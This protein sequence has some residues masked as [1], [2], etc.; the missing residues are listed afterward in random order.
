MVVLQWQSCEFRK[1]LNSLFISKLYILNNLNFL[2]LKN[3][4]LV[5]I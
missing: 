2:I 4:I 1:I 5:I 3:P